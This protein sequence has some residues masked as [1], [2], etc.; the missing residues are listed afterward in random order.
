MSCFVSFY[1]VFRGRGCCCI[2]N[3]VSFKLFASQ[4]HELVRAC[5]MIFCPPS[6]SPLLLPH[7]SSTWLCSFALCVSIGS[8]LLL[9]MSIISNEILV[10][11]P[12]SYYVRWLNTS[13][14]Q[15]TF[16]CQ[17]YPNFEKSGV[18]WGQGY[19]NLWTFNEQF[20]SIFEVGIS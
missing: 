18:A 4:V 15:G 14:I 19:L 17:W 16:M 5:T 6:L 1:C 13:L 8:A 7:L 12:K 11:Y 20:P 2:Q 9:P 3:N 10:H